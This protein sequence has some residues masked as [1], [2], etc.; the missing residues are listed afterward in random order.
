MP[1]FLDIFAGV[2]TVAYVGIFALYLRHFFGTDSN[3]LF[4]GT[5]L[6]YAVLGAHVMY[7][8]LVGIQMNHY[9]IASP[10][11]FFSV[12]SLCVGIIYAVA[13]RRHRDAD[14]GVFFVAIVFLFQLVSAQMGVD[15]ASVPEATR[16]PIYATHV[17]STVLGFAGLTVSAL[18][19]LMYLLLSRQLKSRDLG[20]TFNRLPPL[21]VLEE[22]S[23]LATVLGII[24]L[25]VGLAFGHYV[26][27]QRFGSFGF[28]ANPIIL[29]AD[30]GWVGYLLGL[31]ATRVSGLSGNRAGY[32]SLS[33]Y[34]IFAAAIAGVLLFSG[35]FHSF[36]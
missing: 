18:Y 36:P 26:S 3:D 29:V 13:E 35:G 6:F 8:T 2:L 28:T 21:S 1:Q 15:P 34:L 17:I 10:A 20:A 12:A 27:F 14:T 31:I 7:L 23:R 30:L 5:K 16:D 11:E 33:W 22:M 32:L 19:A 9:P 4:A 24:G 25:G